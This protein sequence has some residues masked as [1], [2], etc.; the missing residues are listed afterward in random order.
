MKVMN[1]PSIPDSEF[2]HNVPYKISSN[3]E[4][5]R[6]IIE[7]CVLVDFRIRQKYGPRRIAA[8]TDEAKNNP[9]VNTLVLYESIEKC[10]IDCRHSQF[11]FRILKDLPHVS[12]ACVF[13]VSK[14]W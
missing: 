12:M 7:V 11:L 9:H 3:V 8:F 1:I 14:L 4:L 10:C 6:K 13:H 5:T 2:P